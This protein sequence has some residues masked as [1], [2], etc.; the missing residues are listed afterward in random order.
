MSSPSNIHPNHAAA[1]DLICWELSAG[2]LCR[3][4]EEDMVWGDG[5]FIPT[6]PGMHFFVGA[7][8]YVPSSF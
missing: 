5:I 8:F 1:P 4:G 2:A 6:P 7:A 3:G